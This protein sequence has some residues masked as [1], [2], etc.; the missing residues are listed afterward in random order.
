MKNIWKALGITALAAA[1]IP[2]RIRKDKEEDVTTVDALLWQLTRR[3]GESEEEKNQVDITI[4]FKSP[5]QDKRDEQELFTEDPDEAVLFADDQPELAVV[6][7]DVVEAAADEV[8]AAKD[9]AQAAA[10]EIQAAKDEAQAAADEAEAA[11]EEAT[12]ED[13]DPDL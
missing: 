9:E 11:V 10:D 3:P 5:L 7:P 6:T 1:V 13:F 8:Q 4:G 12:E 2:Y